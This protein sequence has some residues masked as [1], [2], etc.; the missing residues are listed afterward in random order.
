MRDASRVL[1]IGY[2]ELGAWWNFWEEQG[3]AACVR[4]A[5]RSIGFPPATAG[6][7]TEEDCDGP[8]TRSLGGRGFVRAPLCVQP[9]DPVRWAAHRA[10]PPSFPDGELDD[11]PAMASG[12]QP[13]RPPTL[14]PGQVFK[15]VP[16]GRVPPFRAAGR[17]T[18]DHGRWGQAP[19][20]R[21]GEAPS[22]PRCVVIR[23][24]P[25]HRGDKHRGCGL[26][27]SRRSVVVH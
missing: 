18:Q 9:G 21:E 12:C 3:P 16:R 17:S 8:Q 5:I 20:L 7:S 11:I 14:R 13:G 2:G 22:E 1:M 26:G 25:S 10:Q 23:N 4:P 15:L 24:P 27:V 6:G 19:A